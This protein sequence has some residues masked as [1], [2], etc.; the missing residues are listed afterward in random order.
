[1]NSIY[2]SALH[3]YI[4]RNY[5]N[6]AI[7]ISKKIDIKVLR[8]RL[9]IILFEDIGLAN[10]PLINNILPKLLADDA[11]NFDDIIKK[12]SNSYKSKICYYLLDEFN[13]SMIDDNNEPFPHKQYEISEFDST[14]LINII[15]TI[16]LMYYKGMDSQFWDLILFNTINIEF[17]SNLKH[18]SEDI[19]ICNIRKAPIIW[20][21]ALL[22]KY[23]CYHN[24]EFPSHF[25]LT[26]D[27]NESNN[28]EIPDWVYDCNTEIGR[29]LGRGVDYSFD[30]SFKVNSIEYIDKLMNENNLKEKVDSSKQ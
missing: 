22:Y 16:G 20:I 13:L 4:R 5:P 6:H 2:L 26:D 28:F 30:E 29:N 3:K 24:I 21:F 19:G 15:K 1:M 10:V 23:L 25:E 17:I 14:N 18:I 12:M 27:E 9:L 11:D 7:D 8:N